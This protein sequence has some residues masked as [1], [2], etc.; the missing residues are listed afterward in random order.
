[1]PRNWR[2]LLFFYADGLFLCLFEIDFLLYSCNN[3][4]LLIVLH[5]ADERWE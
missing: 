5:C 1:M 3:G 4:Q 2:S